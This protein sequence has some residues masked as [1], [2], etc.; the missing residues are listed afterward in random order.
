MAC[1]PRRIAQ[2]LSQEKVLKFS[3]RKQKWLGNWVVLKPNNGTRKYSNQDGRQ[4]PSLLRTDIPRFKY[5]LQRMEPHH[6]HSGGCRRAGLPSHR[7]TSFLLSLSRIFLVST[8]SLR[9]LQILQACSWKTLS[10][11]HLGHIACCCSYCLSA[12]EEFIHP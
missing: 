3:S 6:I 10:L 1:D 11:R 9:E 4:S 5:L 8:F 12:L 7:H 2:I